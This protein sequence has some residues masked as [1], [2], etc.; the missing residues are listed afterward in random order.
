MKK[1]DLL[2]AKQ[3]TNEAIKTKTNEYIV[4]ENL[5]KL[6]LNKKYYIKTYGCQ[7]NEHD[8]EN[9]K[10][11]LEDMSFTETED[12]ESA[13]LILLNTC[14]IRENAHNKVFGMIGRIKNLK[15]KNPNLIAGI[16]GCM[17][18][19]EVVVN[20]ILERYNF[21][22]IVFG[23]H[24]IHNLPNIL[25]TAINKKDLEIEVL[26]IEGNVVENIPV[27][28]DS[29]YKAWVNIMYGCDKFC[30]YCIVPYT[31]G[32]QRSREPIYIINEVKELVEKG[33]QEV[34]LLG[35]NVNAY[36]K[37]LNIN[38]DMSNLLE[39][40]AKT[41]INRIRF[42]TSHPWDFNDKMIETIKKYKNIM[43]YIHLPLQ[44]GSDSILKL[45]GRRYT[46]K[47]YIELYKKLKE[48]LPNSSIT[49]D[50]IVGFPNET[51]EDFNE[52]LD[53]VNTCKFDGAFTF[54]FSPRVGTP[55]A[56]MADNVTQEE[57]NERLYKLNELINKYSK[58]A[59]DKYLNKIVPV[60][61]EGTS[62]KDDS[63]LMGY[64]DTMKLVN[65]K[66]PKENIGKIIN[67]KIKEIKTWSMD[68]EI[69]E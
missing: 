22:D 50:I 21:L 32:K 62:E 44:S 7:M 14:A 27:K 61:I 12:M 60:L 58:E 45:M 53:V 66:A 15:E 55:A 36:G 38:Y 39:S 24:N 8:S 30:T 23:T 67:V 20:E 18:Q 56:K 68:G 54:I 2:K 33:Y 41:G 46:K 64:T 48:A 59:N 63:M 52:T 26:S 1:P 69:A 9:I 34:T 10:A 51:E 43:P 25:Y 19:E 47:S 57:K 16:C 40:V 11:I 37:D 65:V 49:T 13:D 17:A 6:G 35:Q 4:K 3:R 31:R 29:K 28:R 42:V 5:K